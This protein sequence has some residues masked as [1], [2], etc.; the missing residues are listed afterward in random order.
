MV[1]VTK[2]DFCSAFENV[3]SFWFFED[4]VADAAG[5]MDDE[6]YKFDACEKCYARVMRGVFE[7][8]ERLGVNNLASQITPHIRETVLVIKK[9]IGG[10]G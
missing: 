9:K 1:K 7:R 3:E 4:R 6:Y 10:D 2:C 5:G 8:M